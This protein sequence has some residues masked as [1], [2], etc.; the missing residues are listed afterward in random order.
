MKKL[1]TKLALSSSALLVAASIAGPAASQGQA[2]SYKDQAK[3]HAIA[4][5]PSAENLRKDVQTLVDFGT[6]HTLSETES[7][8]QGIGAARRWI[9]AEF[10]RIS[11]ACGGCL[12]VYYS[13][14]VIEGEA[15]IPE[16]TEVVSV[17]AI[18]RGKTDPERYVLMAGDIDSRVTDVMDSTSISPGANDN[19]SGLAGTIEAAR[20]LSQ[21]EF[22]GSIVYAALAGEEQG[23]FGGQIL[24]K[25]ALE[26]NWRLHAV[27]NNDMIANIAGI[28]G[29][30]DNTTARVFAEGTRQNETAA[31]AR[32][33]RFTGGEVDSPSRNLGRYISWMA[34][35]YIQNLDV[36]LVYRLDRFGRGGHHR[37]FNDV[38]YPGVRIMETNEHYDRQHQDLRNEDGRHFGDTIEFMDFDYAAKLTALNAVTL[39]SMAWA[40]AP[41]SE[42]EIRGAVQPHTTLRWAEASEQEKDIIAGYRIYWRYTDAPNWQFSRDV[43]NVTEFTLENVVIDNYFFGVSSV[44][45][46]GFESPVVFPGAAGTF[47]LRQ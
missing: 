2:V 37:P 20:V 15:R 24:A 31:D 34:D 1:F 29:V 3:L 47:D 18:Q 35:R 33:R 40:P 30:I 9:F 23:L 22:N 17:V 32:A 26:E 13:T 16:A 46:D 44:S 38:G 25:Q 45:K 8:T 41:P 21:Y 42:V 10:E 6:R 39:A 12:E 7:E 5:A 4:T 43:G 19:A 11:A 27:L 28:N 14:G 36:M